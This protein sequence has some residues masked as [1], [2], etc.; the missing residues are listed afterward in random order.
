MWQLLRSPWQQP[1][2]LPSNRPISQVVGLSE[3]VA[4]A[5]SAFRDGLRDLGY[6][7]GQNL[8]IDERHGDF[9]DRLG[10]PAVDLVRRQM[11]VIVV[12]S[13]T[14]ARAV[15]A[16]T[17]TIPIVSAGAGDLSPAALWPVSRGLAATSP[18]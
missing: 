10:E 17:T 9:G 8:L 4:A 12:P 16:A 18:D 14:V 1:H 2:A 6:V 15:R 13:I 5:W 3:G 7:E 11:E